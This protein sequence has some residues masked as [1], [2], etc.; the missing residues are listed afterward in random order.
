MGTRRGN[1]DVLW[2]RRLN[3]V[4]QFRNEMGRFPIYDRVR[5]QGETVLSVWLGYQ[6]T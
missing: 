4:R 6:R 3:E 5:H 2:D 1:A